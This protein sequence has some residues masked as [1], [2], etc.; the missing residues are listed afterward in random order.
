M[1]IGLNSKSN[2]AYL[3][4]TRA[5]C[6]SVSYEVLLSFLILTPI[7]LFNRF[8]LCRLSSTFTLSFMS[9]IPFII[10]SLAE[11]NR[12]PFDI[13]EGERELIRGFNLEFRGVGF[14][15][16]FLREYGAMIRFSLFLRFLFIGTSLIG[17]LS[18]RLLLLLIVRATFP[19]F[20]YDKLKSLC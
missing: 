1:L 11:C 12:A 2:Y 13:A 3:G 16:I 9:Y 14:A 4:F 7:V 15:L 18:L 8:T 6:Q 19:R 10:R 5:A 17:V 20:R